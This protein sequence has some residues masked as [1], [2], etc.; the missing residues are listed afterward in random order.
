MLNNKKAV[1]VRV[2]NF[3]RPFVVTD[4]EGII[5]YLKQGKQEY[6]FNLP[7]GE[8]YFSQP[9][10]ILN[11]GPPI[12]YRLKKNL[13]RPEHEFKNFRFSIKTEPGQ[14]GLAKITFPEG[15]ISVNEKFHKLPAPVQYWI[16]EHE[17]G[18][19]FYATEEFADM[20]ALKK[21]L[22]AGFNPSTI[23]Q[24]FE[25]GLLSETAE[26]NKRMKVFFG[27]FDSLIEIKK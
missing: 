16:V 11:I 7:A 15:I 26:N 17:K 14:K 27:N 3:A 23:I 10:Q 2:L 9:V 19:Q 5:Y 22:S 1:K 12:E 18:H 21:Y 6:M 20:Y 24:A 13:P 25:S 4:R 8:F